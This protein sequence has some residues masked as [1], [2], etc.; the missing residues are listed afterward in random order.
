M[1]LGLGADLVPV[2]RLKG[3]PAFARRVFTAAERRYAAGHRDAAERL[4]GRFAA[5]EAVMKALG[6]GWARGVAW[7]EIETVNDPAGRPVLRL[8]GGAAR[9][10]R[11]MGVKRWHLSIAHAGGFA[12]ATAVAEGRRA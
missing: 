8:S 4:A 12:L 1:I 11:K 2:A 10:A 5:K 3:R 7:A 9:R 6:T